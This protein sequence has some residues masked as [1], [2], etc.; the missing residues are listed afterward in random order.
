MQSTKTKQSLSRIYKI[1]TG[2]SDDVASQTQSN[3]LANNFESNGSAAAAHDH[4]SEILEILRFNLHE[5]ILLLPPASKI[6]QHSFVTLLNHKRKKKSSVNMNAIISDGYKLYNQSLVNT[7]NVEKLHNFRHN[8]TFNNYKL[9]IP[10]KKYIKTKHGNEYNVDDLVS[11]MLNHHQ[12]DPNDHEHR[13]FLFANETEENMIIGHPGLSEELR[14]QYMLQKT[15]KSDNVNALCKFIQQYPDILD[16]IG[17][18][19]MLMLNFMLPD[20]V[21][22]QYIGILINKIGDENNSPLLEFEL[23]DTISF[24]SI[25]IAAA[26][27]K[28]SSEEF[29]YYLTLLYFTIYKLCSDILNIQYEF[30]PYFKNISTKCSSPVFIGTVIDTPIKYGAIDSEHLSMQ[31]LRKL[32]A[33]S[34]FIF[35]PDI[36]PNQIVLTTYNISDN[37]KESLQRTSS[38]ESEMSSE[39]F[40]ESLSHKQ[41]KSRYQRHMLSEYALN[42]KQYCNGFEELIDDIKYNNIALSN[43]LIKLYFQLQ[44]DLNR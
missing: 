30:L 10:P 16:T 22:K 39:S 17:Q 33:H 18:F 35:A 12:Y 37:L 15:R 25:L 2:K 32:G 4:I 28:P 11:L 27:E 13:E 21:F 24:K 36:F 26:N 9:T 14:N 5:N 23:F 8:F 31:E 34:L 3:T 1:C 40:D 42:L 41:S 38:N 6:K 44:S 29:G 20:E 19:G 43:M 7:D